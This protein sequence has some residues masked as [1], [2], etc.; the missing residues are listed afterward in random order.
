MLFHAT[1]NWEEGFEAVFPAI[2][3]TD[4]ETIAAIAILLLSMVAVVAVV[5]SGHDGPKIGYRLETVET[6]AQGGS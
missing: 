1:Q 5:R 4:W 2:V 6:G 3:G